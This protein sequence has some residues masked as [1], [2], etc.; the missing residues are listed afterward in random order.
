MD[1]F[2]KQAKIRMECENWVQHPPFAFIRI[3]KNDGLPTPLMMMLMRIG[4]EG[5]WLFSYITCVLFIC[6][7]AAAV[8]V[9]LNEKFIGQKQK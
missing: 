9:V 5:F 2:P 4:S 8:S 7:S 3:K 6:C 1:W